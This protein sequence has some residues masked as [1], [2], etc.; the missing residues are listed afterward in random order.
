MSFSN[1]AALGFVTHCFVFLMILQSPYVKSKFGYKKAIP[2]TQ[3]LA[4]LALIILGVFESYSSK[5]Y[6]FYFAIF[7]F[8]IRQPL[9]NIAQPMT[10]DIIMKYVGEKNH[11]IVSALFALIWNG[12][13]QI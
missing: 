5:P 7:F 9:M 8:V 4:V 3:T 6:V 10:T 2:I 13:L 12:S 11:E 1:Y